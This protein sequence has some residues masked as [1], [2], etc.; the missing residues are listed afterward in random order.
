MTNLEALRNHLNDRKLAAA[1][2]LRLAPNSRRAL[3]QFER[4][5][6]ELAALERSERAAEVA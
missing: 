6:E 5:A 1:E 4:A 3:D 2:R